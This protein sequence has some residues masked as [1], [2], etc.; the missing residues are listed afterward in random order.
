[1][2]EQEMRNKA[3]V[4]AIARLERLFKMSKIR[5]QAEALETARMM[6]ILTG[7]PYTYGSATHHRAK[8]YAICLETKK[9][10]HRGER[11]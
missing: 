3:V 2:T 4:W 7:K 11:I 1:M 5:D 8:Y 10:Y 6:R 9:V